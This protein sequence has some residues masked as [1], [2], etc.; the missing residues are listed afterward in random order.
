[1]AELHIVENASALHYAL[2]P[3]AEGG[4]DAHRG[5][6]LL[7]RLATSE[8]ETADDLPLPDDA[9]ACPGELLLVVSPQQAM[10]LGEAI[11]RALRAYIAARKG[12]GESLASF[13]QS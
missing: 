12:G 7:I 3:G 13:P 11:Q 1:M 8:V 5:D 6:C 10:D 2:A 9:P 4:S